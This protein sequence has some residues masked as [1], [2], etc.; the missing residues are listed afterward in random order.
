M[1]QSAKGMLCLINGN[2]KGSQPPNSTSLRREIEECLVLFR[3]VKERDPD[4]LEPTSIRSSSNANS[5]SP[6]LQTVSAVFMDQEK[7]LQQVYNDMHGTDSGQEPKIWTKTPDSK[8]EERLTDVCNEIK[9]MNS[10]L[11]R[12]LS[13][14]N[15]QR[16]I[17]EV[18]GASEAK[19]ESSP[20]SREF[21]EST[22]HATLIP[23]VQ[24]HTPPWV[25]FRLVP[26]RPALLIM[27][28]NQRIQ[29][30]P[31]RSRKCPSF[32]KSSKILWSI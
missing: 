15:R 23:R 8:S 5:A 32:G 12:W 27:N 1:E 29:N 17:Q 31:L 11:R 25:T 13:R 28:L 21:L 3:Q 9:K 4:S 2:G 26:E 24:K 20:V 18:Q 10:Q 19:G 16:G 14:D 6:L 30:L 7:E 22:A